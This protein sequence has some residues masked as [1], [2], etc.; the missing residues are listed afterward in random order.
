MQYYDEYKRYKEV[1]NENFEQEPHFGMEQR[2]RMIVMA[3]IMRGLQNLGLQAIY[4]KSK[5][6]LF[7]C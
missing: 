6:N 4:K 5:I 7:A 2:A 3:G 1:E